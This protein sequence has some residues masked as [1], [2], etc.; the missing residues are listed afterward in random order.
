[1]SRRRNKQ[2]RYNKVSLDNLS[3]AVQDKEKIDISNQD[4]IKANKITIIKRNGSKQLFNPDKLY[5]DCLEATN[6]NVDAARELIKDTEIKLHKEIKITDMYKQLIVTAVNKISMLQ[7]FWEDVAANL[8]LKE[9]Y[10][11][12]YNI[13]G[14]V[15]YPH[16]ADFLAKGI[17]HKIYD[18]VSVAEYSLEEIEVLNKAIQPERDK[19]FNYKGLV[20]FFDK[21]CLNYTK[22]KKLELPQMAYM[23]VAMALMINEEGRVNRVVEEYNAISKH[24]YTVATPIMLNSLTP[25]QQLS[26][27]VL[28]TVDDDSHSILDTG[29]NLGIYSKYKG[30]TA[31]DITALRGKG[32]YIEGTQGISSG[33]T[34]FAKF[35]ESI[36]KAWNQ[37]GKRPGALAIYSMWWHID[38]FDTL[39]LKSNGGTDEN[40]ARGLQY[41]LK[42]NQYFLECVQNDEDIYLFDPVDVPQLIGKF[43]EEFDKL[44]ADYIHKPSI[45]KKKIPART[46]WEK[47]MKERSETGNIYLFHEENVNNQTLLNRYIGSSNLCTEITL[48]SRASKPID[49]ELV[50]MEDGDHRIIKRYKAG[51]IA[52]CN[53][54]SVNLEKWF[55]MTEDE[56]WALIRTIVRALD[57]TVDVANYPV[58]EGKFSN[59]M[60]RYLGIGVLNYANY[61]ALNKI[62]IDSKEAAEETDRLFD[63]LSYMIISVGVELSI[64]KGKFPK[65]HE[66]EWAKGILPIDKA[67]KYAFELTDYQHDEEKWNILRE[68]VR[69]FGVR[70]AQYMA[71]APTATSGKAINAI[72]STEPIADFFYKEEGTMTIPTVV[73]NFRKNNQYYKRNFEC[74]QYALLRNAAIRQKWIDQAQSVNVYISRP[75]SLLELSRLHLYGFHYGM[76]T[77]YYLKQ[78]KEGEEYV[79]ESCT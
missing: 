55:Y 75:D 8:Q 60:Y 14:D 79:C 23:R 35:Y 28:N 29:K 27:C 63:E 15:H 36:M 72:E 11:D 32:S 70:N 5:K 71:I 13:K 6:G 1:M 65:F 54:S 39:S 61:L 25:G 49:E 38:V 42:L 76:K 52:L 26:S 19:L 12:T 31:L 21:Y 18:K 48:P 66:T 41:A 58:K 78:Q 30:G 20:T 37:G 57:N 7:P 77:F 3:S 17:E 24:E 2:K 43:G 67:N 22:T 74:N 56:K 73:P 34:P 64:E 46:L 68:K 59:L 9:Y 10:R 4:A 44:Y 16:L 51:E 50:T 40:R 33:N 45:K 47:L 53:L 62:V 69:T